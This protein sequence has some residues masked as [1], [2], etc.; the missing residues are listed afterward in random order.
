MSVHAARCDIR[1]AIDVSGNGLGGG[2]ASS[3]TQ[4]PLPQALL[5][6]ARGRTDQQGVAGSQK[7]S[8]S[9]TSSSSQRTLSNALRSRASTIGSASATGA[10]SRLSARALRPV[11]V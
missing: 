9:P 2:H 1:Q 7:Q 5:A 3:H 8:S 11:G 10:L 4:S 6:S